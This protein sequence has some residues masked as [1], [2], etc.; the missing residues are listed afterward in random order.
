MHAVRIWYVVGA[1]CGVKA[2]TAKEASCVS[3]CHKAVESTHR[4]CPADNKLPC[5]LA[6]SL[7]HS[8]LNL[9][10]ISP[11]WSLSLFLSLHKQKRLWSESTWT[12]ALFCLMIDPQLALSYIWQLRGMLSGRRPNTA[13][14]CMVVDG[15]GPG[16]IP[17]NSILNCSS[18]FNPNTPQTT[19]TTVSS[20]MIQLPTEDPM[21]ELSRY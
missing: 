11:P 2:T 3:I 5:G 21:V 6:T 7:S 1:R 18:A 14:P 17:P 12:Q 13:D 9:V 16:F 15:F 8:Y 20:R 10:H 19:M 4:P